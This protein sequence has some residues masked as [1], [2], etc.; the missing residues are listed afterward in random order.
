MGLAAFN[1]SRKEQAAK[2]KEKEKTK[3]RGKRAKAAEVYDEQ[4]SAEPSK[5]DV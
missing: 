2:A 5:E 1:R 3:R 4:A